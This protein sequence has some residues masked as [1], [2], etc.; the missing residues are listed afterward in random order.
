[1]CSVCKV[2]IPPCNVYGCVSQSTNE[3]W[4][5]FALVFFKIHVYVLVFMYCYPDGPYSM[6]RHGSLSRTFPRES[7]PVSVDSSQ[8]D[9]KSCKPFSKLW[10]CSISL[11]TVF[12]FV[13]VSYVSPKRPSFDPPKALVITC[14]PCKLRATQCQGQ[15]E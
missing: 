12:L 4:I 11:P 10:C 7:R 3:L 15:T 9:P 8:V 13:S 2:I 5:L 1:M 6:D 14:T